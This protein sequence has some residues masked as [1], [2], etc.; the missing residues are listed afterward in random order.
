[1]QTTR[2]AQQPGES[3]G[4]GNKLE[5]ATQ[6]RL[7]QLPKPGGVIVMGASYTALGVV[8][9]LGRRGIPV[10][11]LQHGD[12][13]LA[14]FSRYV[15]RVLPRLDGAGEVDSLLRMAKTEEL[16]GWL[17]MPT[18]DQSVALVA[19]S[20]DLLATQYALATPPWA[21]LGMV[22]N[23]YS[24]YQLA[25]ALGIDQPWTFC[26]KGQQELEI[27]DC[28]FPVI[29]KPAVR[30]AMNPLTTAKAWRINNRQQLLAR[31]G[32][33]SGFMP[34]EL[35]MIQEIVPGGGETQFS[36]AAL[37]SEGNVLAS[38][39][40]RRTRQFPI[41]FGRSSS[42]V[43][44]IQDPGL[45]EPAIRLLAAVG[46]TGLVELEFKRDTS[47]RFRLLD[48]NPRPWGWHTLCAHAGVDFPYLLWLLTCGESIPQVE[49]VPGIS[50]VHL[51]TDLLAGLQEI[52][53]GR[54]S[55]KSYVRSVRGR[56][57]SAIFAIED[58]V[59]GLLEAP[60]IA[61]GCAKQALRNIKTA[62]DSRFGNRVDSDSSVVP[63]EEPA[64]G[65]IRN[66]GTG[67]DDFNRT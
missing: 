32:E 49:A 41:D 59:P 48:V 21:S 28:P 17:L 24:L 3:L 55:L 51:I 56:R 18:A 7:Y 12:N 36:Y 38:V 37:C 13:T 45:R 19:R 58:P 50:W 39:V 62:P 16:R 54:L 30:E 8:R 14:A 20:Y 43:E 6:R 65:F 26:P 46:M 11:L 10:V 27:L 40:A 4:T 5:V 61:Y 35:L 22:C 29:I 52:A 25:Q 60:L 57:V 15:T 66:S 34:G 2:H 63:T 67:T 31:Y 42:F 23:K 64:T 33:A 47:G 44:T 9:S 1:M 53:R